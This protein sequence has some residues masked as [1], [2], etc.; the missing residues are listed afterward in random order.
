VRILL[1]W[2]LPFG[3]RAVAVSLAVSI[4]VLVVLWVMVWWKAILSGDI[5]SVFRV[6]VKVSPLFRGFR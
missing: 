1:G 6:T 4:L 5:R 2:G 3:S